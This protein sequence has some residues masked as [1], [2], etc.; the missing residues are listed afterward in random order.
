ME[1]VDLCMG[2]WKPQNKI[3]KA[4]HFFEIVSL[5]S[6][7]SIFFLKKEEKDISSQISCEFVFTYRKVNTYIKILNCMVNGYIKPIFLY[8]FNTEQN[9]C[10][11][12]LSVSD[13]RPLVQLK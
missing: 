1:N 11:S 5:E 10:N 12:G 4:T 7:I 13:S 8:V 9:R 2:Y 6:D 3:G